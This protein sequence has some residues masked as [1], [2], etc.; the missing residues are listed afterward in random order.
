MPA[1]EIGGVEWQMWV[2]YLSREG[3]SRSRIT[4][5]VA[6][7][8]AIYAWASVP[9]RQLE[10]RIV[11]WTLRELPAGATAAPPGHCQGV[12]TDVRFPGTIC[13]W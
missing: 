9:S 1:D 6:V 10:T 11:S 5:H 13:G 8:S 4:T 2:D 12:G 3:L 7:A